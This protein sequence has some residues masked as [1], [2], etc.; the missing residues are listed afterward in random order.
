MC[1]EIYI[2]SIYLLVTSRL[3]D[4]LIFRNSKD[5]VTKFALSLR[6]KNISHLGHNFVQLNS[7]GEAFEQVQRIRAD[8]FI[9]KIEQQKIERALMTQARFHS[10]KSETSSERGFALV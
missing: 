4:Q 7:G 10:K 6:Q 2:F 8:S 5:D 9:S 3:K 1:L